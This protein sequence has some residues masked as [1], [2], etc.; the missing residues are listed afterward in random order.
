MGANAPVILG[1]LDAQHRLR[2]VG[3]VEQLAPDRGP[4]VPQVVRQVVDGHPVDPRRALVA[5]D[6]RQRLPQI[7]APDHRLHRRPHRPSGDGRSD[8]RRAGRQQTAEGPPGFRAE[9]SP[10][11]LRSLRAWRS[12]L[13][14]SPP[15]RRPAPAG[16]SAAWPPR[17]L[18]SYLPLPTF[19]PSTRIGLPSCPVELACAI[20]AASFAKAMGQGCGPTEEHLDAQHAE[21]CGEW[22]IPPCL[23]DAPK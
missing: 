12:G 18:P 21:D 10:W 16:S 6:L 1:D 17:D 5:P 22:R 15:P 3:T 19:G 23:G 8:A 2:P 13:H 20:S 14:P 9:K 11:R 4:V 7:V